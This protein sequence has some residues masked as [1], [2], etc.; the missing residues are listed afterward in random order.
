MSQE[1]FASRFEISQSTVSKWE[2]GSQIANQGQSLRILEELR[3]VDDPSDATIKLSI[4]QSA[5]L[6]A[7]RTHDHFLLVA[8][9]ELARRMGLVPAQSRWLYLGN[10]LTTRDL[11]Y[12]RQ[13]VEKGF[14][15][16]EV[17][18]AEYAAPVRN[19]MGFPIFHAVH[20]VF[21][22]RLSTLEVVAQ[23]EYSEIDEQEAAS[24]P[25]RIHLQEDLS[26]TD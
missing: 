23:V 24:I 20:R 13:I 25:L 11:E 12:E 5:G 21:P 18:F 3:S 19:A 10:Q 26:G 9:A 8:S 7:L 22:I 1:E 16:G 14:F 17:A 4:E 6:R 15:R 2:T